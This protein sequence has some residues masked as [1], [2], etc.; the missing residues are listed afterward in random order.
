MAFPELPD[1]RRARPRRYRGSDS[2]ERPGRRRAPEAPPPADAP[3][4]AGSE[5]DWLL[6]AAL[7]HG[8]PPRSEDDPAEPASYGV[9]TRHAEPEPEDD[10]DMPGRYRNG[11]GT[12]AGEHRGRHGSG[13]NGVAA[14]DPDGYANGHQPGHSAPEGHG[15]HNGYVPPRAPGRGGPP[16]ANGAVTD[17]PDS[18]R[19]R[20]AGRLSE[21]ESNGSGGRRRAEDRSWPPAGR[22]RQDDGDEPRA[23]RADGG[24]L[25]SRRARPETDDPRSGRFRPREGAEPRSG[26]FRP[27]EADDPRS[28]H[29]RPPEADEFR[30]GRVRP[31]E[32]DELRPG[33]TGGHR[34]AAGP[35]G[36]PP[37]SPGAEPRGGHRPPDAPGRHGGPANGSWIDPAAERGF[38]PAAGPGHDNGHAR[39]VGRENGHARPAGRADGGYARP[40]AFDGPPP[41][42]PDGPVRRRDAGR[43]GTL[44]PG[45]SGGRHGGEPGVPTGYEGAPRRRPAGPEHAPGPVAPR[46][47]IG[48]DGAVAPPVRPQGP[49][50]GRMPSAPLPRSPLPPEETTVFGGTPAPPRG[51]PPADDEFT[52]PD[53]AE[54]FESE[55]RRRRAG[56]PV[57][58]APEP[59]DEPDPDEQPDDAAAESTNSPRSGRHGVP[60]VGIAGRI[61]ALTGRSKATQGEDGEKRQLAFWKE[62]LLLAG[63]AL[64]LTVLI[65]TFLAKVYVIP[66]G[67]MET[68]LHG[69]PGCTNDRVLV[70]KVTYNFT[71]VSPGDIVVF[72]GTEGWSAETSTGGGST[73][74]IL[75]GLETVGSL[76]G[77]A[78][79]D[80]KDFVKRVIAVGGQTVACCDALNQVMVD[81]QPLE[82]PYVYYLPE[83]GP[84]RQIPFGP[85]T[86]PEGE[87]WMMGDSRNNSAD[88]RAAGHGPIP[89]GNVIGKA[90]LIVLPFDR[91]GWLGSANPQTATA[92]AAPG[93]PDG[94]PLALGMMGALPFAL[95]RRRMLRAR[96]EAER[97]LPAVRPPS[98]WRRRS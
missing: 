40:A 72:R 71:D 88:S 36:A 68:T 80:E 66:S 4:G 95:G 49:P 19:A 44:R 58:D 60:A 53:D 69:C 38:D 61:A 35:A 1:D 39:P 57:P 54:A 22:P 75:R 79:P 2:P 90:R 62:L 76:V 97:F 51:A 5:Q 30:S 14:P 11:Y 18:L 70:D 24:E 73:N 56:R 15:S 32:S 27:P 64:L 25:R 42:T 59:S 6:G 34:R 52:P 17:G 47:A 33:R 85:V 55:P 74:P 48:P 46:T 45:P 10:R 83:A 91:F 81:G 16:G 82:E 77:F 87:Y 23:H 12:V 78:P 29:L 21:G 20:Y 7:Q 13:S 8:V 96:A 65:Q 94:L 41:H 93:L 37:R 3:G 63:V 98:G 67:S 86:V 31:P 92:S 89:D 84:A 28:G 50:S 9:R 43:D 26:H